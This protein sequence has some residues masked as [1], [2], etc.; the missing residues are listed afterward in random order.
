M[1]PQQQTVKPRTAT[2]KKS[3]DAAP[4]ARSPFSFATRSSDHAVDREEGPEA[5]QEVN[6]EDDGDRAGPSRKPQETRA[7]TPELY[8]Q[9]QVNWKLNPLAAAGRTTLPP[10]RMPTYQ[11]TMP[12]TDGQILAGN[13]END[14]PLIER[15]VNIPEN[16]RQGQV[17]IVSPARQQPSTAPGAMDVVL[18][19]QQ[20]SQ[21]QTQ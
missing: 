1:P 2:K 4:P 11:V 21:Q 7:P 8:P 12:P 17:L 20:Q 14:Q 6:S 9:A 19:M 10:P 13:T 16:S 18:H 5:E 15:E 3:Q